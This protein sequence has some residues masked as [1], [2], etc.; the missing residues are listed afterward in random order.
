M[1]IFKIIVAIL[2][3]IAIATGIIICLWLG[4]IQNSFNSI[5]YH[6]NYFRIW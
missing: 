2:G 4:E 6:Y 3:L 1:L 5:L